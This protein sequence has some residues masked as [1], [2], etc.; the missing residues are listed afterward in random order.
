MSLLCL[1]QEHSVDLRRVLRAH[2]ENDMHLKQ[3]I[4]NAMDIKPRGHDFDLSEKPILM[5]HM[6]M[7]GG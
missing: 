1:G 3:T 7:T 2:P 5:R 4:V 6:N